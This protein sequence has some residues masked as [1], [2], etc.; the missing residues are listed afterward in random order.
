MKNLKVLLLSLF[1]SVCAFA[2]TNQT[3]N[4]QNS[5]NN[6]FKYGYQAIT[7]TLDSGIHTIATFPIATDEAGVLEAQVV[8][9]DTAGGNAITG[10]IIV[11]YK[12]KDGTLTLG[13][14]TNALAIETDAGLSGATFAF[15][16][17]SNN[18]LLRV[19]GDTATTVRWLA[20]IRLINKK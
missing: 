9:I 16:A 14:P 2:Q 7:T 10:S 12:K 5:N 8:G 17:A 11:R 6:L 19:T 13:S 18:V 1:V 20:N 15:S 4:L 3:L